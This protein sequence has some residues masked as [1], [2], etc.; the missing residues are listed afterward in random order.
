MVAGRPI[1]PDVLLQQR[2]RQ[3]NSGNRLRCNGYGADN[4]LPQMAGKRHGV[5]QLRLHAHH[6]RQGGAATHG[7]QFC[8]THLRLLEHAALIPRGRLLPCP[9]RS[10]CPPDVRLRH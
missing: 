3:L 8:R 1:Q 9:G 4:V 2:Q 5:V 6:R 10:R 7:K